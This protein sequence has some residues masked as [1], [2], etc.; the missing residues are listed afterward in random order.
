MLRRL[1]L[2]RCEL[3]AMV[4]F[5]CLE[6]ACAEGALECGG[7]TPPF[8]HADVL[9]GPWRSQ[10]GVKPPHSEA[11]RAF[12]WFLGA[13]QRTGINDCTE[14]RGQVPSPNYPFPLFPLPGDR[15]EGEGSWGEGKY[16]KCKI[17]GTKLRSA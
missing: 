16:E 10:G 14:N 4:P 8:R 5:C 6:N 17:V 3:P 7:L 11:L 12:S 2:F 1:G 15:E 13:R 9:G